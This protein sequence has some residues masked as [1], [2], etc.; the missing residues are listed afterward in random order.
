M[1]LKKSSTIR[2]TVG[3]RIE[4]SLNSMHRQAYGSSPSME[5]ENGI[6]D[7]DE[8]QYKTDVLSVKPNIQIRSNS[9]HSPGNAAGFSLCKNVCLLHALVYTSSFRT[10]CFLMHW[11]FHRWSGCTVSL[12][13]VPLPSFKSLVKQLWAQKPLTSRG[14]SESGQLCFRS[15]H[16]MTLPVWCVSAILSPGAMILSWKQD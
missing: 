12:Y 5:R 2:H 4:V 7:C 10:V 15:S 13:L 6:N 14:S 3:W 9:F 1:S 8:I 16:F 11:H